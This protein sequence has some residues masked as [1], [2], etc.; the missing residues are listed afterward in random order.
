MIHPMKYGH[1]YKY[2]FCC[3]DI[4][5]LSIFMY[6]EFFRVASLEFATMLGKY[7]CIYAYNA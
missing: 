5:V 6:Y 3:G 4:I 2:L 7:C 1:G